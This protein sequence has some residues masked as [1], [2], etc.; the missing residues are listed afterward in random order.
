[1]PEVFSKLQRRVADFWKELDKSQKIRVY[2]IAGILIVA[3]AIGIFIAA[4]TTYV[5][6]FV[7]GIPEQKE[8]SEIA[9]VLEA[10]S[11]KYKLE[12]NN[13]LIDSRSKNKAQALLVEEGYPKSLDAIFDDGYSN[14]I[15]YSTT[16]SDKRKFDKNT[17]E[18]LL[19]AKLKMFDYI[20]DASVT[21][22]LPDPPVLLLS[23]E[24]QSKP[25]A[26][27]MIKPKQ[28]LSKEQVR[29]VVMWVAKSVENLD[30]NDIT[31]V[32]HNLNE[33]TAD[34][35]DSSV[36]KANDQYEM[37]V[38]WAAELERKVKRLFDGQYTSF[39][40]M[41]VVANPRLNFNKQTSKSKVLT[42]PTE[43]GAAV[44]NRQTHT[45]DLQNGNVTGGAPGVGTNPGTTQSPSYQIEANGENSTYKEKN[46]V[47]NNEYNETL[48]ELEN[49]VGD[50]IPEQSTIAVNVKY[51]IKAEDVPQEEIE[52]V[53]QQVSMAT[54]I[55]VDNISVNKFRIAAPEEVQAQLSDT[56]RELFD[57]YGVFALIVLLAIALMIAALPRRKKEKLVQQPSLSPATAPRFIVP[58]SQVEPIPEIDLEERSEVKKQIEKFVKQKPDA[59]AQLL[60][61]WLS[62][63]WEG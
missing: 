35:A 63:E 38:K 34:T 39:D 28:E 11:L 20:E 31:V 19:S 13:I 51:G 60:R 22:A 41:A 17:Q 59:V 57:T 8:L 56:I 55:P 54:S 27:V 1:M 48:T 25:T 40:N 58:E 33:L 23:D 15:Q 18:R 30:P 62:D 2:I 32:D 29:S 5:P 26:S 7:D 16:E 45:I 14:K 44:T 53:R 37:T 24:Q 46:E 52:S 21:L 12:D 36:A 42:N 50:I 9:A 10:G 3:V 43:D 61:N 49:S 47:V 6:L 4:R